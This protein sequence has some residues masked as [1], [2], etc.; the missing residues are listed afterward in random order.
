LEAGVTAQEFVD[1]K[2]LA[3]SERLNEW[4]EKH[5]DAE[6]DE[7]AKELFEILMGKRDQ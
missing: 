6:E 1:Q 7:A 3:A 2:M 4:I 5:P